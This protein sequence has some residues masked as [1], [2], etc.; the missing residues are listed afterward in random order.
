MAGPAIP[1]VAEGAVA[2]IAAVRC[3]Q[4]QHRVGSEVAAERQTVEIGEK[5]APVRPRRLKP[6]SDM[7]KVR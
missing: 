7:A 1:Y 3:Q 2:V 4:R 6:A 5:R